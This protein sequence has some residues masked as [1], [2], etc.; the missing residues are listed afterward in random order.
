MVRTFL[1]LREVDAG[2]AR[3]NVLTMRVHH[4]HQ[5]PYYPVV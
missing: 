1:K 5:A 4:D 3:E 2:F